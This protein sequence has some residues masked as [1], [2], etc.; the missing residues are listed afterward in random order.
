MHFKIKEYF[1]FLYSS[2]NQ[3]GVHSPFVYNLV[4]K[5]FYNKKQTPAYTSIKSI[6]K[7]SK[8][9]VTITYKVAKLLNRTLSYFESKRALILANSA[10]SISQILSTN[11]DVLIDTTVSPN[12]N[13]YDMIYMDIDYFESLSD[14]TSLYSKT[15]NNSVIIINSIHNSKTSS[16]VWKKIKKDS[17]VTVTIDTFFLGFV[18]IRKEQAKEDFIIRT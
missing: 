5:C 10:D 12:S 4:T 14:L 7:R 2:T 8:A 3:H 13:E 16:M 6:L 15:N 1:K 18:F 9:S 11:N 17:H